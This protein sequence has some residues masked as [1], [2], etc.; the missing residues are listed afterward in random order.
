[1]Q[2]YATQVINTS[3]AFDKSKCVINMSLGVGRRGP[4]RGWQL[5]IY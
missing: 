5:L 1:M 2:N 4:T 3:R